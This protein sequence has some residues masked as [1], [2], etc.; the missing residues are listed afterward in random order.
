MAK[1]KSPKKLK[2]LFTICNR[3]KADF[4]MSALEGYEVNMQTVIY[5]KGTAPSELAS[6]LGAIEQGKA[7]VV[8]LVKEERVK[9]ILAA[10][11]DKYFKVKG[12]KG[13]AFTV[14]IDSMIGV[15][16]YL[17][18]SNMKEGGR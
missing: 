11:E 12:A 1:L 5:A 10:Y 8:S 4:F 9:E 2:M 17:F 15:S 14:P 18:L 6:I 7:I 3:S 13:V 16:A